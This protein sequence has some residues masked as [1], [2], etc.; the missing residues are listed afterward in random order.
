MSP[1]EVGSVKSRADSGSLYRVGY[2][3]LN[4]SR[5]VFPITC[6]LGISPLTQIQNVR[7]KEFSGNSD[8]L[9]VNMCMCVC[10]ITPP[11]PTLCDLM[12]CS[13]PGSSVHGDSPGKNTGV[14]C[15]SFVQGIFPTR[16]SNL[17]LL[18]CRQILYCLSH[19]GSPK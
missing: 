15:H 1:G 2:L 6:L 12:G 4:I 13:L 19:Q 17:R 10:L 18:P 9:L 3:C 11:C 14:G 8:V 7:R 16:E 5:D